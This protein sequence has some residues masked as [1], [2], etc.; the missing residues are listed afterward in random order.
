[1]PSKAKFDYVITTQAALE[2]EFQTNGWEDRLSKCRQERLDRDYEYA[3]NTR[4]YRRQELVEHYEG[5]LLI[6]F[7]IEY[8]MHDNTTK[9]KLKMLLINGIRHVSP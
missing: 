3:S 7:T 4:S 5:N 6:A 1:M 8:T 2:L 9:T